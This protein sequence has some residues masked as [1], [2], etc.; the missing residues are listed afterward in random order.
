M[1]QEARA[2]QARIADGEGTVPAA[3]LNLMLDE[4]LPPLAA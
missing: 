4:D 2:T 1:L 3:V